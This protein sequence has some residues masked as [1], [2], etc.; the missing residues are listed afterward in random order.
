V[1]VAGTT[2][3]AHFANAERVAAADLQTDFTPDAGDG[4]TGGGM[5]P[6]VSMNAQTADAVVIPETIPNPEPHICKGRS[7]TMASSDPEIR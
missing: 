5:L 1:V 4:G 3:G 2:I 7:T 6:D